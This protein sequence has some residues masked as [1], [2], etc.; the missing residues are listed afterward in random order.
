M[1][2]LSYVSGILGELSLSSIF[3]KKQMPDTKQS[4]EPGTPAPPTA[5]T[6]L[7]DKAPPK[8]RRLSSIPPA[9][10]ISATASRIPPAPRAP[11]PPPRALQL[12]VSVSTSARPASS[13]SPNSRP[14]SSRSRANHEAS[15]VLTAPRQ[16]WEF[17]ED[18]E[19]RQTLRGMTAA[20]PSP[21]PQR[22]G[23]IAL[24]GVSLAAVL[25]GGWWFLR[26]PAPPT[27]SSQIKAALTEQP[28][29]V[30]D[31]HE[32]A[33]ASQAANTHGMRP[34]SGAIS[35]SIAG[36]AEPTPVSA[37]GEASRSASSAMAVSAPLKGTDQ[38]R[39]VG[40]VAAPSV[41]SVEA[42]S[43]AAA[44]GDAATPGA[45]G[46][47]TLEAPTPAA[48]PGFDADAAKRALGASAFTAS[49]CRKGDD[50]RGTAE[51]IVTFAPS[52]RV[53]SANV[54]GA[55]F[56]GTATG[57]C[58][59]AT[60]RGASVPPFAGNHVSVRKLVTVR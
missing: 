51:V 34:A 31:S 33:P 35:A 22:D 7:K 1:V 9:L 2:R 20:T 57:G 24:A 53:T 25:L 52:G 46:A 49:S 10:V 6:P 37:N 17:D 38:K 32:A 58:I 47:A 48:L 3:W 54:N 60:L 18:R 40:D 23:A 15:Q 27:P 45:T 41:P 44:E 59:A 13:R 12:A 43:D 56:G 36:G 11:R 42:A 5:S 4:T 30:A 14:Q 19:D 8:P 28:A 29:P 50:P 16:T 21:A 55:P 26:E 39:P